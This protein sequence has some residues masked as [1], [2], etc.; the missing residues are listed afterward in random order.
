MTFFLTSAWFFTEGRS[1]DL[2]AQRLLQHVFWLLV[3]I[4]NFAC[5]FRFPLTSIFIM[6]QSQD[7]LPAKAED[8]YLAMR[9]IVICQP[10]NFKT[11]GFYYCYYYHYYYHYYHY[12]YYYYYYYYCYCY[13]HQFISVCLITCN[14]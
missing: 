12:Y 8:P 4:L 10:E 5:V 11:T 7:R 6:T 3:F 1:R 14:T 2:S 13:C 9:H